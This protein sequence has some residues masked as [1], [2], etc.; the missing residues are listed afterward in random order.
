LADTAKIGVSVKKESLSSS[1]LLCD[2][3]QSC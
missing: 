1:T 3:I 2:I